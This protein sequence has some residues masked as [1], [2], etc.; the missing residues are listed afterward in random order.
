MRLYFDSSAFA[1]RYIAE[2]GTTE[3]IGFQAANL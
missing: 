3:G 2:T 1:K